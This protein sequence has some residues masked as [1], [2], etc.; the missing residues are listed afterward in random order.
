MCIRDR[1]IGGVDVD[2][3]L[4]GMLPSSLGGDAGNRALQNL[5]KGLLYAFAR[6]I[7]RDGLV[8]GFTGDLV[9]L[10]NIDAVSYTHLNMKETIE[11]LR[12]EVPQVKNMVGGAVLTQEYADSIWADVYGK[13]AMA[14]VRYAT[15]LA[16]SLL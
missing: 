15:E 13:D 5:Q 7:P 12:R 6:D 11:L 3:L 10:I 16:E 9:D 14:S 4:L 1:D 8:L 2:S